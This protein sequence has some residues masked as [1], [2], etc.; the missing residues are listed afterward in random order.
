MLG[1][2]R[3]AVR[4][5]ERRVEVDAG[6]EAADVMKH[7]AGGAGLE[8]GVVRIEETEASLAHAT[9]FGGAAR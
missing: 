4:A 7:E 2:A 8:G 5:V 3:V 1:A 6:V 9:E